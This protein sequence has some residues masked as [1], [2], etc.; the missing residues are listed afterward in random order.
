MRDPQV[1]KVEKGGR[2]RLRLIN[3]ATATAFLIDTG[4]LAGT[5]VAV[6]GQDIVPLSAKRIPLTMGQR[7]DV[8]LPI[9]KEGGVFP[10]LALREGGLERTGIVLSTFGANVSKLSEMSAAKTQQLDL[11]T[12]LQMMARNP[13]SAKKPDH[14][15]LVGLIGSMQG[16]AWNL[17]SDKPLVVSEGTRV[18]IEMRNMSMMAHPMHLHGHHFQVVAINGTPFLGA[19]RDTVLLPPMASVTV[20][21]NANNPGKAWAYH[22]HNLYHMASGMMTT[23]AYQ[24]V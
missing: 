11:N 9:P 18:Q 17:T 4:T 19:V 13:L 24:G 22:C 14:E 6:D 20:A 5:I 10:I 12:E 8:L 16:Y 23:L 1:T 3:G 15:F 21:F 7:V 2:V